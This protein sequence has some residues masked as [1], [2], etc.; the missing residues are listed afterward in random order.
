MYVSTTQQL[1][2]RTD[3]IPGAEAYDGRFPF[4]KK[5]EAPGAAPTAGRGQD[6]KRGNGSLL[7]RMQGRG[8]SPI[9]QTLEL[10]TNDGSIGCRQA[11]FVSSF[12][13][14]FWFQLVILELVSRW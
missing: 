6:T 12:D 11:S 5:K 3:S 13:E 1:L 2:R 9:L 14:G 4:Q 7:P 8:P 10:G